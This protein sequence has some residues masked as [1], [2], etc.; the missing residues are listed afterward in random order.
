MVITF[1]IGNGFDV[2][3]GIESSYAKFYDW[4]CD[5]SSEK[6]HIERFRKTI[7]EDIKSDVPDDQ[8]TW[9]DFELGLGEYTT[10][11]AKETV[12]DFLDCVEDGQE[13]IRQYLLLQEEKF[14]PDT[15]SEDS[16]KAFY[17]SI[18]DFYAEVSDAEKM[19]IQSA[20]EAHV[21][22]N[23]EIRFL[24]FNYTSTLE[25]I[26]AKLPNEPFLSWTIRGTKYTYGVRRDV[27]HVHGTTSKFPVLGV[28]DESQIANKDLLE[29]PQ[30]KELL[31]KADSVRALGEL[32]HDDAEKQIS[33]STFVCILGMS[34]GDTDAKWWKKLSQ[35]L[36]EDSHRHLIIYWFEKNPPNGI[37]IRKEL[38]YKEKVKNRLVSFSQFSPAEVAL[39]KKRIHVIINTQKFLKLERTHSLPEN[40]HENEAVLVAT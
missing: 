31:C 39:L 27:L 13:N 24:T 23:K 17:D 22:D 36:K 12:A 9:A 30:F 40:E 35:W 11:F 2:D 21:E 5:Q 4:Y 16:Y 33:K 29:T 18:R 32:W 28:N 7:K 15:Y 19:S 34:L 38:Q 20:I 10:R 8:R 1:I 26:I 25:R 37:S 3:K 6:T 14:D